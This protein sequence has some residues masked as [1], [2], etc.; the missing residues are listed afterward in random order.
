MDLQSLTACI[1]L[2]KLFIKAFN[3]GDSL[4]GS[5]LFPEDHFPHKTNLEIVKLTS[6]KIGWVTFVL[7]YNSSLFLWLKNCQATLEC[8]KPIIHGDVSWWGACK[9]LFGNP[10]SKVWANIGID[11]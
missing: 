3:T 7:T 1:L 4:K 6:A 11:N 8:L 2:N 5:A 9:P 10:S